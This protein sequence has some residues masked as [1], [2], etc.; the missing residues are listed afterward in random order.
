MCILVNVV[1]QFVGKALTGLNV[2][3]RCIDIL[4]VLMNTSD[5]SSTDVI[6]ICEV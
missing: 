6:Q 2:A 4:S 3:T 5:I 1:I